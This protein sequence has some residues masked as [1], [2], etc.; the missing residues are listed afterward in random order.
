MAFFKSAPQNK[1]CPVC[2]TQ[3]K[4]ADGYCIKCGYSFQARQKSMRRGV[5]WRNVII[6][7]VLLAIV[8][9]GLR[10]ANDLTII[11]R[12]LEDALNF[13]FD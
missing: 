10:Y 1:F 2:G 8:Y 6:F 12:S 5:K 4:A 11:P 13:K 9:F 3:L 7:L